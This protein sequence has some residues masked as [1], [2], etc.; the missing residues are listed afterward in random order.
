[1]EETNSN[2]V[3]SHDTTTPT[4]IVNTDTINQSVE[5]NQ[6][7]VNQDSETPIQS[8]TVPCETKIPKITKLKE[9][10]G[11]AVKVNNEE[12]LDTQPVKTDEEIIS[13]VIN[14]NEI[15]IRM[16][17]E[18]TSEERAA[19]VNLCNENIWVPLEITVKTLFEVLSK[20]RG[21][22]LKFDS[23]SRLIFEYIQSEPSENQSNPDYNRGNVEC[24]VLPRIDGSEKVLPN[25]VNVFS[26]LLWDDTINY[27]SQHLFDI[28]KANKSVVEDEVKQFEKKI[29]EEVRK[30]KA[31]ILELA[32]LNTK[33]FWLDDEELPSSNSNNSTPVNKKRQERWQYLAK[34]GLHLLWNKKWQDW[35]L[36]KVIYRVD[37]FEHGAVPIQV[38]ADILKIDNIAVVRRLIN[39]LG[40][41]DWRNYNYKNSADTPFIDETW[42]N[43]NDKEIKLRYGSPIGWVSLEWFFRSIVYALSINEYRE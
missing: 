39:R 17:I 41:K 20:E 32:R 16:K 10:D 42:K 30:K 21:I 35:K 8:S 43:F 23:G 2:Q 22:P 4:T 11:P 7:P 5:T 15:R 27:Y 40:K 24:L 3:A 36:S 14:V 33:N 26:L 12:V 29:I 1:M 28:L 38:L 9:L 6:A 19:W 18:L 13:P 25:K 34:E 37:A 31:E